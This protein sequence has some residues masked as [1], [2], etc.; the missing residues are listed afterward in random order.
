M[1]RNDYTF[2]KWDD[3]DPKA[4]NSIK[5][6]AFDVMNSSKPPK[7]FASDNTA[8]N[9]DLLKNS[10]KKINLNNRIKLST[11]D[12]RD[13]APSEE[14]GVII[15]NPPHG[16]RMGSE[17]SLKGLY[18]I[19]GDTFKKNCAGF[20]AYVFCV[21]NSLMKSIG[22]QPKSKYVLKNGKLDCRFL[23]FPIKEG[24]FV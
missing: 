1:N 5:S 7:I 8:K 22:L 21:N 12:I 11:I 16:H 19:M 3:F 17:D 4:F 9:I 20:D 23:H 10:L 2:K 6:S 15:T 14:S 18:R 24:K 13:F